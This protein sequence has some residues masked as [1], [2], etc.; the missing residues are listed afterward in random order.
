MSAA[1]G[2][3]DMIVRGGSGPRVPKPARDGMQ[4]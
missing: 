3:S 2:G 1:A 4:R